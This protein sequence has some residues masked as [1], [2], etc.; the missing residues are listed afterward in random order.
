MSR[1]L[2]YY[3]GD[4]LLLQTRFDDED[5]WEDLIISAYCA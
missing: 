3:S 4:M 5:D 1:N 2:S